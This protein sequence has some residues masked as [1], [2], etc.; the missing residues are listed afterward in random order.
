MSR[1][2]LREAIEVAADVW[3]KDAA[4]A[5]HD[6]EAFGVVARRHARAS[7]ALADAVDCYRRAHEKRAED[8]GAPFRDFV[9]RITEQRDARIRMFDA[10]A[11]LEALP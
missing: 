3:D 8:G 6:I 1:E 7:L 11:A 2:T 10:L 5:I 9:K 4:I